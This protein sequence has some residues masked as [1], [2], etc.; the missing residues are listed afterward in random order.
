MTVPVIEAGW[1]ARAALERA[2]GQAEVLATLSESIYLAA[3]DEILWLGRTGSTLH[4]RA[5]LTPVLPKPGASLAL[6]VTGAPAWRPLAIDI[7][8]E[9][10]PGVIARGRSLAEALA[11]RAPSESFG[12]LLAG[13]V[14]TFPLAGAVPAARGLAQ[15]CTADNPCEAARAAGM[16]IGLGPGLTPAGD[17]YVG[18]AFFARA[19]LGAAGTRDAGGWRAAAEHVRSRAAKLTHPISATLLSDLLA[20]EG[21]AP[22]HDLWAALVA[23]APL[24]TAVAA[25]GRLTA[26]GHSSGWDMLAGFVGALVGPLDL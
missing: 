7:T 9:A 18:G 14:P 4:G 17:D 16:L 23:D 21:H 11:A 3:A 10:L 20:G 8:P 5:V 1:R 2:Q 6:D 25:A 15:A 19:L 13:A 24:P 26:L 22:F 12:A